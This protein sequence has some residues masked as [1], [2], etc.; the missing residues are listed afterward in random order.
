MRRI[1]AG[2][3]GELLHAAGPFLRQRPPILLLL[4][5]QRPAEDGSWSRPSTGTTQGVGRRTIWSM[6]HR[7][8][9]LVLR[10]W[11]SS[12]GAMLRGAT[13]LGRVKRS[14]KAR[15]RAGRSTNWQ[16]GGRIIVVCQQASRAGDGV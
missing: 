6:Y 16:S 3:K 5:L 8:K 14:T 9:H 15:R 2:A 1:Y 13:G 7:S 12:G 4:L 11:G 10:G